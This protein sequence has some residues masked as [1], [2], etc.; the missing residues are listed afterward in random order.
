MTKNR[1]KQNKVPKLLFLQ[2]EFSEPDDLVSQ[3][4]HP[5]ERGSQNFSEPSSKSQESKKTNGVQIRLRMT[6]NRHKQ[7]KVP[8]LLFQQTKS[9][10]PDDLVSQPVHPVERGSQ[11]FSEPSSK[12]QESKKTNGVQIRLRMTENRHKRCQRPK[13]LFQQTEFSE[14]ADLVSQT[15]HPVER[16]SQHLSE[17]SSNIQ[18]SKKTNQVE[19]RL[20]MTKNRYKRRQRPKLLFQQTEFSEP[21][22]LVSQP[23]HPVER[24]SQKFS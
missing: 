17:P 19:N 23:V 14:P 20:R 8:K 4:V 3:P 18:E 2:T 22:N 24:G 15:V 21:A 13:L 5:V 7:D 1:H 12:S 6:E 16:S 9:S 10:E 11:N